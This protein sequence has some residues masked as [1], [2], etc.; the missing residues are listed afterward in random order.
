VNF[1]I[2]HLAHGAFVF[3]RLDDDFVRADRVHAVVDAFRGTA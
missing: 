1:V 2:A 3:A